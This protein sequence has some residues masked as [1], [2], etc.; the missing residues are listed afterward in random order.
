MHDHPTEDS[1]EREGERYEEPISGE[2]CDDE[3]FDPEEAERRITEFIRSANELPGPPVEELAEQVAALMRKAMR[4][5]ETIMA[6]KAHNKV[7]ATQLLLGQRARGLQRPREP[8]QWQ[9]YAASTL[10]SWMVIRGARS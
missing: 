10:L 9:F 3:E 4:D 1:P 8:E 2:A 6:G 7:L 5:L